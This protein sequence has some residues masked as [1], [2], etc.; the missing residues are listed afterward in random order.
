MDQAEQPSCTF[1]HRRPPAP[2]GVRMPAGRCNPSG[3][4]PGCLPVHSRT[5]WKGSTLGGH[6]AIEPRRVFLLIVAKQR[7]D[8]NAPLKLS[9]LF[10]SRLLQFQ[11]R[12]TCCK[13][14]ITASCALAPHP[15][16]DMWSRGSAWQ[17]KMHIYQ[18]SRS[19]HWNIINN[20]HLKQL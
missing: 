3:C 11:Q 4:A 17:E 20:Q 18:C 2:S 5:R 9:L 10:S 6:Q 16:S 7:L 1:P 15:A 8:T 13:W 12:Y 14:T 19:C